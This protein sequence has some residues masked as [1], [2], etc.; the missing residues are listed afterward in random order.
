MDW[1]MGYILFH[2]DNAPAP[3]SLLT[4]AKIKEL[5]FEL[6]LTCKKRLGGNR[7]ESNE[8]V[9]DAV[10]YFEGEIKRKN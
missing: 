7:I 10:K 2:H 8:K 5:E 3:S 1:T 9:I 4:M 6:F